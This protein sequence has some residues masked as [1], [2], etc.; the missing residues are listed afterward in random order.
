MK[1]KE[2]VIRHCLGLGPDTMVCPVCLDMFL[3][4]DC[5]ISPAYMCIWSISNSSNSFR[6]SGDCFTNVSWALQH[7]LSKFVYCRNPTSYE[8]FKVKLLGTRTKFQVEILT[9][10]MISGIEI[11]SESSQNVS[12]TIPRNAERDSVGH[13]HGGNKN[14]FQSQTINVVLQWN[15]FPY[16]CPFMRGIGGFTSQRESDAELWC[17][18]WCWPKQTMRKQSNGRWLKTPCYSCDVTLM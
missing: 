5:L 7:I 10:N 16:Y 11:I 8:S 18:I 14:P 13:N 4:A 12:K 2:W 17:F 1:A 3:W 15:R 9:I 6:W